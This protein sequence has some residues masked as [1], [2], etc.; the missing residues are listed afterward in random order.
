MV[1]FVFDVIIDLDESIKH[2]HLKHYLEEIGDF[3]SLVE[4]ENMMPIPKAL[5]QSI[6]SIKSRVYEVLI[7]EK[8]PR[9]KD[10]K[11]N[12]SSFNDKWKSYD[13]L[14]DNLNQL[15]QSISILN[16]K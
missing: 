4:K 2:Y 11:Q 6:H 1:D 16:L 8:C 10:F 14:K 3:Y 9:Y 13:Q 15:K 12:I 7:E 5:E